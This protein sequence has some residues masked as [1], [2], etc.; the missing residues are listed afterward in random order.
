MD[1]QEKTC[2][3]CKTEKSHAEFNKDLSRRDGM[4]SACRS[5]QAIKWAICT[6]KKEQYMNE[7]RFKTVYAGLP[8]N[9]RKVYDNLPHEG[10]FSQKRLS[11]DLFR[12]GVNVDIRILGG[13]INTLIKCG[14][15]VEQSTGL[16]YRRPI[17]DKN[18]A[19]AAGA[20]QE[21][22]DYFTSND[23]AAKAAEAT[24]ETV[25]QQAQPQA[26]INPLDALR[27]VAIKFLDATKTM[28]LLTAEI[29]SLAAEV[30]NK[31][32]D[33]EKHIA[34][35]DAKTAKMKQFKELLAS[36]E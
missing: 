24:K 6:I 13:I 31:V 26:A 20:K 33:V 10:Y 34:E 22:L 16:F 36:I 9:A 28:N 17:E 25:M 15:V 21:Q 8:A 3:A 32:S 30:D 2:P 35:S 12:A 14:F 27:E 7:S 1:Q 23:T 4:Q 11:S 19:K 5:C 29:N 18:S